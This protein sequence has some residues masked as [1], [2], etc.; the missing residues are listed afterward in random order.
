MKGVTHFGMADP[1]LK[2]LTVLSRM[3]AA[4]YGLVVAGLKVLGAFLKTTMAQV[5]WEIP[6]GR[7]GGAPLQ[8]LTGV[9]SGCYFLDL[10]VL[11]RPANVG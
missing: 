6:S 9:L 5:C 10:P 8:H 4:A 2:R 11:K 3:G 7:V 1:S